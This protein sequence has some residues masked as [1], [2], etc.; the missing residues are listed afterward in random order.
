VQLV[1]LGKAF[2]RRS[3]HQQPAQHSQA[4][5]LHRQLC[6]AGWS[7]LLTYLLTLVDFKD[8]CLLSGISIG[9]IGFPQSLSPL[10]VFLLYRNVLKSY[11]KYYLL[12][13]CIF[14]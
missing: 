11:A 6:V 14:S 10:Q 1:Q 8:N 4:D 12:L 7:Q 2:D 9:S 13:L 5:H 3:G